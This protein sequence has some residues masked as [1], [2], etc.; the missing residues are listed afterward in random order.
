MAD[1]KDGTDAGCLAMAV[2]TILLVGSIV[3]FCGAARDREKCERRGMVAVWA[4]SAV[5]KCLRAPPM[6]NP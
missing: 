1:V 3:V 5:V 2:V 4:P 6:E